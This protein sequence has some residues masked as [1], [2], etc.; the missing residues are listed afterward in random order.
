MLFAIVNRG[1]NAGL[2]LVPHRFKDDDRYR[3]CLGSRSAYIPLADERDIPDYLANGYSLS[4]S[5]ES[6][7]ESHSPTLIRP[8]SI[9]GWK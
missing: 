9:F 4:M 5:R 6:D 7:S 1:K 3:V 2:R 8:E